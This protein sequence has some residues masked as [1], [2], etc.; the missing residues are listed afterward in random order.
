[1]S[2]AFGAATGK[3]PATFL[4]QF[5]YPRCGTQRPEVRIGP[6]TGVDTAVIDLP[7][8][9]AMALTTDPCSLLPSL[10][11]KES[12]WLTV[13]LAASDMATTGF[14]PMY[15]L[16]DLNL[17][18]TLSRAAFE[19]YW[20]YIHEFCATLGCAIV[21][22]HTGRF[23]GQHS[24][25]AG[26]ATMITV[27]PRD[28]ILT[29]DQANPGDSL[30]LAGECAIAATAILARSFPRTITRACGAD[31]LETAQQL[32][33]RTSS[34]AAALAAVRAGRGASGVTAMHDV[35]EGG[36]L[37]ALWELAH[38]A[39][40]GLRVDAQALAISPET[41]AVTAV[42]GLDPTAVVG[43][44]AMIVAVAPGR[45]RPVLD[46]LSDAGISAAIIGTLTDAADGRHLVDAA[47]TRTIEQAGEDPYWRA[48][49]KAMAEGAR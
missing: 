39:D 23:D 8:G 13:H 43:A 26:G 44:G 12:A 49:S 4:E 34:V 7:G 29:S 41:R 16:F 45:E 19:E 48:F 46:A 21:G 10:G 40:C 20:Q 36:V 14:A 25:V 37:G 42:F 6:R 18:P 47:G 31:T 17:P 15:A 30:I 3:V 22:G 9:A 1:M 2:E 24:T 38:A 35:T 5:V 27:A 11:M 32:F 33:W 28:Q